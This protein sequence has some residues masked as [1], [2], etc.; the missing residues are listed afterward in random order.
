M[1]GRYKQTSKSA[2]IVSTFHVD[3]L[4]DELAITERYNV[5]PTDV[6]PVVRAHDHR[7]QLTT[8]RCGLI[9]FWAK[10]ASIGCRML[11]A[12]AETLL[13]KR[14]FADALKMRRCVVVTDGFY[15]WRKVP[16]ATAPPSSAAPTARAKKPKATKQPY[17]FA[18]ED[19]RVFAFAGLWSSWRGPPG[20]VHTFTIITGPPN[21][22]VAPFHDRMPVIFDPARDADRIARWLD[23]D[24][25]HVDVAALQTPRDLPGF[26]C[27]AVNA[28]VGNVKNDD[29]TLAERIDPS[30]IDPA[31]GV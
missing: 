11:N 27:F 18:F 14:V 21:A 1:C 13:E 19:Q 10:D 2:H 15:E 20:T 30:R 25:A 28:R 8:M 9:P 26:G 22:L 16:A 29:A 6:M 12:R 4:D 23:A 7:R 31:V 5:A 17:L 24:L 3:D